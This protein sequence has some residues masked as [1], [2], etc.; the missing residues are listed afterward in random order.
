M[1]YKAFLLY[2]ILFLFANCKNPHKQHQSAINGIDTVKLQ[3]AKGFQILKNQ[4]YTFITVFNPWA[5]GQIF[6][7]YTIGGSSKELNSISDQNIGQVPR[8]LGISSS[9][10]LGYLTQ[11]GS[12]NLIAGI[13]DG[14]L[15]YD[16]TIYHSF[17]KGKLPSLGMKMVDNYESIINEGLDGYIKSGFEQSPSQDVRFIEAGLPIIYLNDWTEK[18]PLARAE[19]IKFIACFTGQS[20]KA[21]SLFFEIESRYLRAKDKAQY[22]PTQPTVLAGGEFKGE[23]FVPGGQSYFAHLI[24][25]AHGKYPWASDTSVG[26]ITLS[27]E[28][29]FALSFNA[30]FWLSTQDL[31]PRQ[32]ID[33]DNR[34]QHLRPVSN[35]S[36]YTYN[37]RIGLGGG[38]DYWESGVCRPDL[39]LE[40]II[41]ILH[42]GGNKDSL[43]YFTQLT[44]KK[45]IN[46]AVK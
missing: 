23:W 6:A 21:D 10:A 29:V 25:D 46:T 45:G 36:L 4:N 40:D 16:T 15:V 7:R 11:L 19:W 43:F 1:Y 34:L 28:T 44:D 41:Q 24:R 8:R 33:H 32:L 31:S 9:T 13:C 20:Q 30:D 12:K 5:K 35:N 17:I 26:S 42:K 39:I 3:Y 27:F 2:P 22:F 18:S 14:E 37:K 38:N